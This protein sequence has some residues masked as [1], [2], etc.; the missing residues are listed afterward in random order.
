MTQLGRISFG[1]LVPSTLGFERF[2]DEVEKMLMR[3][4]S[5]QLLRSHHITF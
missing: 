2:F 5:K 3:I 4:S 1:P